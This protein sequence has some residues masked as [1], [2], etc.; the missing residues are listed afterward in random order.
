M[1]DLGSLR[2]AIEVPCGSPSVH[3]RDESRCGLIQS[4]VGQVS[5]CA[6]RLTLHEAHFD[7]M[8]Q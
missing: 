6:P 5:P 1:L 7:T 4:L 8:T 2:E 3:Y